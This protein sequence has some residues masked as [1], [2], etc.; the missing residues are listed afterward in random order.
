[1]VALRQTPAA[2]LIA[3]LHRRIVLHV[4]NERPDHCLSFA[5][6]LFC[7]EIKIIYPEAFR[8]PLYFDMVK[9]WCHVLVDEKLVRY[10]YIC[11]R[12]H[13]G[14]LFWTYQICRRAIA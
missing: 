2:M 6:T 12:R 13:R 7:R 11:N 14:A 1:M 10:P 4:P 9:V 8:K 3:A 5:V